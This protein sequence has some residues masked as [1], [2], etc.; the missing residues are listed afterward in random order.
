MLCK[1]YLSRILRTAKKSN[2]LTLGGK[3]LMKTKMIRKIYSSLLV[4]II[5]LF[6]SSCDSNVIGFNQE[7]NTVYTIDNYPISS[8]LINMEKSKMHFRIRKV[9]SLKGSTCIKL[10]SLG[11]N[12][13]IESIRGFK[14]PMGKNVPMLPLE[15][16]EINHSS[17]GDAASCI[18]YV[19]TDKDGRV[20]KV[21][22]RYEYEK[23][24]ELNRKIIGTENHEDSLLIP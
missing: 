17:I 15:I 13:K 19:L 16:Y 3:C 4:L 5:L 9:D 11:D 8:L 10:D 23:Q 20:N 12:Y 14:A 18:I 1:T 6:L 22:R 2:R 24:E 21:M 7:S